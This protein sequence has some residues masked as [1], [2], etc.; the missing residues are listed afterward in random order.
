MD[1]Q[2][3]PLLIALA[4]SAVCA[5]SNYSAY[6]SAVLLKS[7]EEKGILAVS[8]MLLCTYADLQ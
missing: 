7:T 4:A 5:C 3:S 2:S 6:Q 1:M 8:M